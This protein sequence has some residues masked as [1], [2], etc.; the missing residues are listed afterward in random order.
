M[1]LFGKLEWLCQGK[2]LPEVTDLLL[3]KSVDFLLLL[4]LYVAS[5]AACYYHSLS[6]KITLFYSN[7]FSVGKKV[8]QTLNILTLSKDTV[9]S[10]L[11]RA[12]RQVIEINLPYNGNPFIWRPNEFLGGQIELIILWY[13]NKLLHPPALEKIRTIAFFKVI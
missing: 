13:V 2:W 11:A 6:S 4:D 3:V 9:D 1:K 10:S 8:T 5:S 7:L 12:R